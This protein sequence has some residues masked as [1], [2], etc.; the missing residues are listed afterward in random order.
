MFAPIDI[1]FIAHDGS[2]YQGSYVSGDT[3]E[4]GRQRGDTDADQA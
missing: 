2:A 4:R 3:I 1:I